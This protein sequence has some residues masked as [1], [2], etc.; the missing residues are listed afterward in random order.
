MKKLIIIILL[1]FSLI[2]CASEENKENA[3]IIKEW[4]SSIYNA[5]DFIAFTVDIKNDGTASMIIANPE[6]WRGSIPCTFKFSIQVLTCTKG[7]GGNTFTVSRN[8]NKYRI[9][10]AFWDRYHDLR[11]YDK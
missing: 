6:G 1:T 9:H 10:D 11:V 2:G 5:A 3:I 4:E 7:D 8:G